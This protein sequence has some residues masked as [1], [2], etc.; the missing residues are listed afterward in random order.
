MA[1]K[2]RKMGNDFL[3]TYFNN[4]SYDVVF[5]IG[6]GTDSDKEGGLYSQYFCANKVLKIDPNKDRIGST[7]IVATCEDLPF[8]ANYAN[9][10]FLNWVFVEGD[11]SVKISIKDSVQELA[12]ILDE[13]GE[14]VVSYS[15]HSKLSKERLR[16]IRAK[17]LEFFEEVKI[18]SYSTFD[19]TYCGKTVDWNAEIFCGKLKQGKKV[20]LDCGAYDGCSVRCFRDRFD[21]D[22]EYEIISFEANNRFKE[23]FKGFSKHTFF[24]KAI[25]IDDGYIDF[26]LDEKKGYGSS[27]IKEKRTGNL[28]K[29]SPSKVECISLSSF[30]LNNISPNDKLI[31]K[32]DIEGAEYRVLEDLFKTG[33]IKYVSKLMVEWHYNKIGL[34]LEA[35]NQ[36]LA[37]LESMGIEYEEWDA[38]GY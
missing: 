3:K 10:A 8:R 20:F 22:G 31:L 24:N 12:R 28:N 6:C 33:A 36:L 27:L 30:I 17:L 16:A 11:P 7:D 4:K 32:L 29:E 2:L 21:K 1:T 25:W 23:C 26:Y 15:D 19:D 35:H 37:K 9:L 14:V 13:K 38:I 34:S 5:N 18:Y